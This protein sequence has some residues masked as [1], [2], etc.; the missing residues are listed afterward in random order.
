MHSLLVKLPLLA[1]L[2]E[3]S[4]YR[5]LDCFLETEDDELN[6]LEDD[7]LVDEATRNWLV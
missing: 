2:K 3:R 4:T 6:V 5:E 1:S 7:N